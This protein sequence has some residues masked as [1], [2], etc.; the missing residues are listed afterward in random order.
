MYLRL[1]YIS[2]LENPGWVTMMDSMRTFRLDVN[3]LVFPVA[4]E[5]HR[6]RS[7]RLPKMTSFLDVLLLAFSVTGPVFQASS[8]DMSF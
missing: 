6:S 8:F 5:K 2:Y 1:L 3:Q 7:I 4:M